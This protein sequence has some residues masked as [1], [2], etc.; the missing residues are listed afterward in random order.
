MPV[1]LSSL[2]FSSLLSSFISFLFYIV[3]I[4][5]VIFNSLFSPLPNSVSHFLLASVFCALTHILWAFSCTFSP[6]F[7]PLIRS[8]FPFTPAASARL[9]FL[10]S[11]LVRFLEFFYVSPCLRLELRRRFTQTHKREKWPFIFADFIVFFG[12]ADYCACLLCTA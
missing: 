11:A 4:V 12:L 3:L 1:Y 9:A 5:M 2:N 7:I 10:C 8:A 6:S